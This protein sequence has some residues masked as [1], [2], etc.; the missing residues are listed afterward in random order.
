M[1]KT[2]AEMVGEAVAQIDVVFLDVTKPVEW[3]HH[4][5][6]DVQIPRGCSSSPACRPQSTTPRS[7]R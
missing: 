3:E 7:D 1:P 5:P 4:M 2:V 6:G